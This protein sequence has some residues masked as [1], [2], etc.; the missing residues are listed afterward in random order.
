MSGS[1]NNRRAEDCLTRN[2]CGSFSNVYIKLFIFSC[3]ASGKREAVVLRDSKSKGWYEVVN[4]SLETNSQTFEETRI[5]DS[6][7]AQ[8]KNLKDS[9]QY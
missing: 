9:E 4:V 7:Q 5:Q 2:Y 3:R 8:N 1:Y 6:V